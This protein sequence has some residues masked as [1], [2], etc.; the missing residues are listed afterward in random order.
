MTA[1]SAQ[2]MRAQGFANEPRQDPWL[3][4]VVY[5]LL[6]FGL[7]MVYSAGIAM[8]G[9]KMAG[10]FYYLLRHAAHIVLGLVLM[11]LI[12]K[13]KL[14]WWQRTGGLL[15]V[16]GIILLV[17]VLVPGLS[18]KVNGSS[19]W[20]QLGPVN[21]QPSEFAKLF[22]IVY[23]AGY[24]ARRR[25]Q[26]TQFTQGILMIGMVVG[27]AGAL[28]IM[29]PDFGSV[30]VLSLTVGAMLF[31]AGVRIWQLGLCVATGVGAMA[32]LINTSPEHIERVVTFLD[33]W[34]DPFGSGFQL[35]QALIAFGRGDWLGVGLGGSVQKLYYLPAANTDFLLAVI[36][37]ELGFVGVLTI[38]FL[39]GMLMWRA[40]TI[41]RRAESS[42]QFFAARLAQ[43]VGL[44]ISFQ[45]L[46]NM[47]VNLGALP[48]KGLTLPLM[49]YGGSSM[50]A[51]SMA[52]GLLL[53]VDR[54]TR[55]KPG[56][57]R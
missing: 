34:K 28:L 50:L 18:G 26:L 32:I 7:V 55:P 49:S 3:L 31:L 57:R 35:T 48:T 52:V 29:E 1:L 14:V 27:L 25:D 11:N 16:V 41:S 5:V 9:D 53:A 42:G 2:A 8:A 44:Y 38:V 13:V 20:F 56:G 24:L 6:G 40:L 45:A 54:E 37:E 17:L 19:R 36:G 23:A 51:T 15:V 4:A 43:G 10:S 33:P 12:P 47:G 39:F 30:V 21:L 22:V 46:I